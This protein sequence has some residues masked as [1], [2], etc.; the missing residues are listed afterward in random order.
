MRQLWSE[1]DF[2]DVVDECGIFNLRRLYLLVFVAECHGW[3]KAARDLKHDL[4]LLET[5]E[6]IERKSGSG[7][8]YCPPPPPCGFSW[9]I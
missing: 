2:W 9:G 7:W 1:Q 6:E 4:E 5:I 3:H 8:S